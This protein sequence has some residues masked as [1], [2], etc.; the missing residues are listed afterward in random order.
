MELKVRHAMVASAVV[1]LLGLGG[2]SMAQAQTEDEPTTTTVPEDDATTP[3]EDSGTADR[4]GCDR[5]RDGTADEGG[6]GTTDQSTE[7]SSL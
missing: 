6:T 5:D 1:G 7:A 4:P 3:E 2:V